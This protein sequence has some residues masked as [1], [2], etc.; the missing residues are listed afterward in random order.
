MP[1]NADISPLDLR[2]RLIRIDKMHSDIQRK[3]AD[4][5]KMLSDIRRNYAEQDRRQQENRYAPWARRVRQRGAGGRGSGSR[6]HTRQAVRLA[7]CGA[8][9]AAGH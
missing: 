6:R 8:A 7:R 9:G 4:I 1:N 3:L 2:E 5:D